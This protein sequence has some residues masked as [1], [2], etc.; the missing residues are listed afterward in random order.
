M[1]NLPSVQKIVSRAAPNGNPDKAPRAAREELAGRI[2]P[3]GRRLLTSALQQRLRRTNNS[4]QLQGFIS[5]LYQGLM[6]W[7]LNLASRQ[8]FQFHNSDENSKQSNGLDNGNILCVLFQSQEYQDRSISCVAM[9]FKSDIFVPHGRNTN[10]M[11]VISA[12]SLKALVS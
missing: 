1:L 9:N 7:D 2:W 3:A 11:S 12:F 10:V 4:C 5:H 6:I 8:Q